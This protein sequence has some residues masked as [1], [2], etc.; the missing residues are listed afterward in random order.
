M[1]KI[2]KQGDYIPV[3]YI[4]NLEIEN[5]KLKKELENVGKNKSGHTG[6]ANN[7]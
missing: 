5:E 2:W 6:R 4:N 3:D 7:P 1:V